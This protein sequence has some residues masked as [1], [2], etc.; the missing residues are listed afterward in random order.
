MSAEHGPGSWL[1][2]YTQADS[3]V[4]GSQILSLSHVQLQVQLEILTRQSFSPGDLPAL[5]LSTHSRQD[6]SPVSGMVQNLPRLP[7]EC[8]PPFL[9]RRLERKTQNTRSGPATPNSLSS[10]LF[11]SC[12]IMLERVACTQMSLESQK[13]LLDVS[14]PCCHPE[15][16]LLLHSF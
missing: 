13:H 2:V 16:H 14:I 8:L 9:I 7:Q 12:P 3:H 10:L 5:S 4:W 1:G 15:I 6:E 11:Y